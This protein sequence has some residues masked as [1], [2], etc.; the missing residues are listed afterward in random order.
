M[1]PNTEN[2]TMTDNNYDLSRR[3]ALLGLGTI[4]AAGVG[5]GL[6]TSALFS[7]TETFTNNRIQAGTTNLI[8]D[9][10]VASINSTAPDALGITLDD[11]GTEEGDTI[12]ADGEV[13]TGVEVADMKPGDDICLGINVMVEG[14]P[15][16]VGVG[17][18]STTDAEGDNPE[19][20]PQPGDDPDGGELDNYL[21]VTAL[22]Y[23]TDS[24]NAGITSIAGAGDITNDEGISTPV[25]LNDSILSDGGLI[26]RNHTTTTAPGHGAG[27]A[28]AVGQNGNADTE[29]VTHYICLSLPTEVGNVVQGDVFG[30]ELVFQAEQVRNNPTE[31]TAL[32]NF[33]GS[34]N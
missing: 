24:V 23:D 28:T 6:G 21:D 11:E 31:P 3:K 25:D 8:V 2:Q 22:G 5:A 18:E 20:E 29:Q 32:G 34:P 7:D 15:M 26:Y 27:D 16:Y 10:G 19:P 1:M 13:R 14:N 9:L 4:G 17:I 12:E 33:D 30:F